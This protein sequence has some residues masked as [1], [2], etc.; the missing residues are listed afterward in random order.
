MCD[1]L[2]GINAGVS[3]HQCL[4]A[5][6]IVCNVYWINPCSLTYFITAYISAAPTLL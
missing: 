1:I 4:A 2:S 5:T 6:N 3:C